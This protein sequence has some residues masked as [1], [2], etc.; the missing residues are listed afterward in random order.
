LVDTSTIGAYTVIYTVSDTAENMAEANR[1]VNIIDSITHNQ[2]TYGFVTS[3]YTA[4][5]WLDRNLG[6][7]QVCTAFD[8]RDCYGDYYQW[9]RNADGHEDSASASTATKATDVT[10]VGHG[11]FIT[12][13]GFGDWA[14]V[15][16]DE[17]LIRSANWSK[18]DGSSVCPIGF[19]VPSPSE[20]EEE[21]L[22][23]GVKD[24]SNFLK[25]PFTGFRIS[26]NGLASEDDMGFIWSTTAG[27][28]ITSTKGWV[29]SSDSTEQ[30]DLQRFVGASVRCIQD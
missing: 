22:D 9:G 8:D 1:M 19:R 27:I 7:S 20:V 4:K 12:V 6:A 3:P 13:N 23:K 17:G 26:S 10:T 11:N 14:S 5:I 24:F 28:Q 21:I 2:I 16:T 25:L 15:D 29:F 30:T 18:A